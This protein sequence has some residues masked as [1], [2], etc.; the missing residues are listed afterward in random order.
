MTFG[1]DRLKPGSSLLLSSIEFRAIAWTFHDVTAV[2]SP[3]LFLYLQALCLRL[4]VLMNHHRSLV[5]NSKSLPLLVLYYSGSVV[6]LKYSHVSIRLINNGGWSSVLQSC[7]RICQRHVV[8]DGSI[9][10]YPS[11]CFGL[12]GPRSGR[13]EGLLFD[14]N[15]SIRSIESL[16]VVYPIVM[17]SSA[18]YTIIV[19]LA[20]IRGCPRCTIRFFSSWSLR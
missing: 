9:Q 16:Q 17:M 13:S 1:A 12:R 3:Q 6:G 20:V 19:P 5:L 4:Q 14:S 7:S 8:D 10:I 15:Q 11:F 2:T 18:I